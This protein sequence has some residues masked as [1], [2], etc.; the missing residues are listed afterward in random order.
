MSVSIKNTSVLVYAELKLID[1]VEFWDTIDLPVYIPQPNDVKYVTQSGD[2]LDLLAQRYYQDPL[3]M[4][5]IAWANDIDLMPAKLTLNTPL[6]IPD[7]TYVKTKLV[8][9]QVNSRM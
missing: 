3:L 1:G 8:R 4:W 5:V 6:T 2:R 7:P 9:G